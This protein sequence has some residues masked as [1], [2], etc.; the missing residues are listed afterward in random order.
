VGYRLNI[1]NEYKNFARFDL[2][3]GLVSGNSL[4][5][6]SDKKLRVDLEIYF[7]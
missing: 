1:N 6:T 7:T 5:K 2:P 3:S 4:T